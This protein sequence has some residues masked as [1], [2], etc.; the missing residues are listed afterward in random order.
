MAALRL[1]EISKDKPLSARQVTAIQDAKRRKTAQYIGEGSIFFLL[2][3]GGAIFVF[4]SVRS[5][6]RL[7]QQQHDF[8]MA[9]THELKTPIAVAR[10]NLETM[11]KHKLD[12]NQQQRLLQATLQET[13]R[14]NA[15]SNNM[16]LASQMEAG[17]YKVTREKLEWSSVVAGIAEDFMHRYPLRV[18]NLEIAEDIYI[19]GDENWLDIAISNLL[20]N[21]LKYSPKNS[22]VGV[23]LSRHGHDAVLEIADAGPGIPNEEKPHVTEKYYRIGN[24]A[25]KKAKGTGLGLHITSRII[26]SHKGKL[27]ILDNNPS[28]TIFVMRLPLAE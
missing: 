13:N 22:S 7:S 10:L 8:M 18:F 17:A 12:E 14:L 24:E 2:I 6:L 27:E 28:G 1:Q 19:T 26:H 4:R 25:T 16:L 3:I 21:A 9:L 15:L 23:R 20:D 11:Q 5:Q